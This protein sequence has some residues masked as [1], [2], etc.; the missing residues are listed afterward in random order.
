V[1]A[2]TAVRI[3]VVFIIRSPLVER[4]LSL[5]MSLPVDLSFEVDPVVVIGSVP[6]RGSADEGRARH[7]VFRFP[8]VERE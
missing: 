2:D 8:P 4:W 1:A 6:A 3:V 5:E 7:G